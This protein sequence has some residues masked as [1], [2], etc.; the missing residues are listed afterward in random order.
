MPRL[1]FRTKK[2]K[3]SNLTDL[4]LISQLTATNF[5]N[6][7]KNETKRKSI[8]IFIGISLIL[9]LFILGVIPDGHCSFFNIKCL[10]NNTEFKSQN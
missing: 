10:K 8:L 3:D 5:N 4:E 2:I 7:Q 1:D 6:R 9:I